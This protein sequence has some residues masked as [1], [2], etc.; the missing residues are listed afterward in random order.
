MVKIY[1]ITYG[2]GMY[3]AYETDRELKATITW[4]IQQHAPTPTTP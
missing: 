4:C 2:P 3:F 1:F